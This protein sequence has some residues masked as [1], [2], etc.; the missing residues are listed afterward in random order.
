MSKLNHLIE[1]ED[2][3]KSINIIHSLSGGT[4]SG[5]GSYLLEALR[6]E[7]RGI[8]LNSYLVGPSL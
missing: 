1:K 5:L 2:G 6:D 4:G 7:F 3:E 8:T